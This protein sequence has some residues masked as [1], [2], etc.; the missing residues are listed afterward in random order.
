[1]G[2]YCAKAGSRSTSSLMGSVDLLEA[3]GVNLPTSFAAQE[4]IFNETRFGFFSIEDM[5]AKFDERYGNRFFAPHALS[6]ALP[7]V[8]LPVEVDVLMYGYAAPNIHL[9]AR[10]LKNIGYKNFFIVNNTHNLVHYVDEMLPTGMTNVVGAVNGVL[11]RTR[12]F[13]AGEFVGAIS[14]DKTNTIAQ[15]NDRDEQ[16]AVIRRVLKGEMPN[17][18]LENAICLNAGTIAYIAGDAPSPQ[19]G[20]KRAQATIANGQADAQLQA[21]IHKSPEYAHV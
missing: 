14:E 18:M 15:C 2:T 9:S 5:I 17:S 7:A 16:V 3:L 21:I 11:G 13:N 19:E 6:L 20:F 8:V 4:A 1:M 10:S 12:S